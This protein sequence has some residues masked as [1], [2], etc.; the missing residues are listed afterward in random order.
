[1]QLIIKAMQIPNLSFAIC[2]LLGSSQLVLTPSLL[3]FLEEQV[4]FDLL[5]PISSATGQSTSQHLDM[6]A[7]V[8]V[9]EA[10]QVWL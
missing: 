8:M 9:T 2:P 5:L 10:P 7:Q 3:V 4:G 6:A 1:M